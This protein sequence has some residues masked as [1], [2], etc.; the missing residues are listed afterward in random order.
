MQTV[1]NKSENTIVISQDS[2]S[3]SANAALTTHENVYNEQVIN[4]CGN[5]IQFD[6]SNV[7]QLLIKDVSVIILF[8]YLLVIIHL[9]ES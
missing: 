9:F 6:G 2:E 3:N 1:F 5:S 7:H 8:I 4:N